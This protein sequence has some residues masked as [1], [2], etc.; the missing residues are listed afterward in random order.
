MNQMNNLEN[1]VT[2]L[3]QGD[4]IAY[5][6]EAVF[7]LG[8]NPFNDQAIQKLLDLKQRPVEKGLILIAPTLDFFQQI[9][10]FDQLSPEHLQ[11]IQQV[12]ARPTTW[13]VPV[14]TTVS[15]LLTGKFNSIAVRLCQHPAVVALCQQANMPIT[16]TSA[17]LTG[18][19]PCRHYQEV[20][21]QFG[22]NFPVLQAEVG[23]AKNPSEIRD[24]FTNQIVRQG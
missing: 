6:T 7:G 5:P 14:Q 9:I 24:L 19:P 23:K 13:I 17:N 1:I 21:T 15:P 10:A 8:C 22:K 18:Q 20:L 16:S 12:Y 3:L 11:R 2:S 4:V